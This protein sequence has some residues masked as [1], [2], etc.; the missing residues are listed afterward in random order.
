MKLL[1]LVREAKYDE[2]HL[3]EAEKEWIEMF[4]RVHRDEPYVV[5]L[6]LGQSLASIFGY[7]P[8]PSIDTSGGD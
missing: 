3:N 2:P 6:N 8:P 5:D 7:E 4:K 1:E